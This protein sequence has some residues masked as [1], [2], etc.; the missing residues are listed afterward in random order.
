MGAALN[1]EMVEIKRGGC[2]GREAL[3]FGHINE[4]EG[5]KVKFGKIHKRKWICR[6][7]R[8]IDMPGVRV[9]IG[10]NLSALSLA[11]KEEIVRSRR[12]IR[13]CCLGHLNCEIAP[14]CPN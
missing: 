7:W 4:G 3:L 5:G 2:V 10:G 9:E 8:A 12:M 11:M 14:S 13:A 6:E 1:P